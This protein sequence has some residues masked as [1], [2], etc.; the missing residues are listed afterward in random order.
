MI[1]SYEKNH[2]LWSEPFYKNKCNRLIEA[3]SYFSI[4][5]AFS[6]DM[7]KITFDLLTLRSMDIYLHHESNISL[8]EFI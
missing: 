7:L 8:K 5:L 1:K 3:Y 2:F 4:F 6:K